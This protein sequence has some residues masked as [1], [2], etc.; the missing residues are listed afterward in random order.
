M[1]LFSKELLEIARENTVIHPMGWDRTRCVRG[2][3]EYCYIPKQPETRWPNAGEPGGA[4][5]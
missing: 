4:E 1:I 3:C 5:L 2:E